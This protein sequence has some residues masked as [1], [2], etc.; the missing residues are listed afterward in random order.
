VV[1]VDVEVDGTGACVVEV[2]AIGGGGEFEGNGGHRVSVPHFPHCLS[3]LVRHRR[4]RPGEVIQPHVCLIAAPQAATHWPLVATMWACVGDAATAPMMSAAARTPFI[5]AR[6]TLNGMSP[7]DAPR[8]ALGANPRTCHAPSRNGDEQVPDQDTLSLLFATYSSLIAGWPPGQTVN[9]GPPRRRG[10]RR[11]VA[12]YRLGRGLGA[13]RT[14]APSGANTVHASV[15]A[16]RRGPHPRGH[17]LP[18]AGRTPTRVV[19]GDSLSTP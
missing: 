11:A 12:R 4:S 10:V 2:V 13:S 5:K 19:E 15:R 14:R 7:S 1:V 18:P 8:G 6:R 9:D 3:S 17:P 16:G